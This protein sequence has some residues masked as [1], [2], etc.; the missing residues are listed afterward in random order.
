MEKT[1][2][3]MMDKTAQPKKVYENIMGMDGEVKGEVI[4]AGTVSAEELCVEYPAKKKIPIPVKPVTVRLEDFKRNLNE[5]VAG[6][7]LPPFLLVM[8][9]GELLTAMGGVAQRE[10]EQDQEAWEKACEEYEQQ[11]TG[12][13]ACKEGEKDG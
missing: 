6:S 2:N 4:K 3:Q 1:E 12:Q 8:V 7:E 5:V 11:L 9:L 10:Y 13:K